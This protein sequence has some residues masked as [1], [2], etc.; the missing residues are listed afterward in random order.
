M[1]S[2]GEKVLSPYQN[3]LYVVQNYEMLPTLGEELVARLFPW[4][5]LF[6]GLFLLLGLW[7]PWALRGTALMLLT[8]LVVVGQAM[9]RQLPIGE[10]G[11]FGKLISLPL[12]VVFINDSVMLILIGL[13]L[14]RPQAV[15]K[16]SLDH[17]F[18]RTVKS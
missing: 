5:E 8:F 16:C 1:V 12:H 15:A 6:L 3:F 10:C 14:W 18:S 13:M 17:Y 7:L 2:G 9:L 4:I 11:C